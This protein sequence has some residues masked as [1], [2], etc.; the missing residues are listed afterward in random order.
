VNIDYFTKFADMRLRNLLW[1]LGLVFGFV[2]KLRF[3]LYTTGILKRYTPT[4]PTIVVGNLRVGGTGKTPLIA[5]IAHYLASHSVQTAVLSRGYKRQTKGFILLNSQS[6]ATQVGDEPKM[7]SLQLP[8]TALA[9][10]ENRVVGIQQLMRNAI[11]TPEIILLDDAFQH[12]RLKASLYILT[13]AYHQLFTN[14][15]PMPHGWLRENKSAANRA[16]LIVITKCPKTMTD[17]EKLNITN[18]C[19]TYSKAKCVFSDLNYAPPI[20]LK[21]QKEHA[22]FFTDNSHLQVVTALANATPMIEYIQQYTQHV[23]HHCFP[24]HHSFTQKEL[25]AIYTVA[26]KEKQ[27]ILCTEKDAVKLPEWF[28]HGEVPC[29]ILPVQAYFNETEKAKLFADIQYLLSNFAA[30]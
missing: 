11:P 9:V 2:T 14:D 22:T 12:H 4:V 3:L 16:Q 20:H 25:N 30:I 1:P 26:L 15:H 7:L 17:K 18:A 6:A 13:T 10:C 8:H 29:Y 19:A 21:S 5:F 23:K 24:D 27:P 28:T